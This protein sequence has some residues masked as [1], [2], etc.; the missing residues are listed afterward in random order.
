M[1][2]TRL[3]LSITLL[4][5]V[6]SLSAHEEVTPTATTCDHTCNH[7]PVADKVKQAIQDF[8]LTEDEA[9]EL[10]KYLEETQTDDLDIAAIIAEMRTECSATTEQQETAATT[11]LI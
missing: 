11:D 7:T 3:A 2:I 5:S 10:T 1:N 4:T 8:D 9:A 6:A